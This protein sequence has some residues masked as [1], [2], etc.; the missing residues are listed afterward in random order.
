M[1][2]FCGT[3]NKSA[4]VIFNYVDYNIELPEGK[5]KTTKS[6]SDF[7]KKN[8]KTVT[9]NC[10]GKEEDILCFESWK[11]QVKPDN[12]GYYAYI[13]WKWEKCYK[14]V[15][16]YLEGKLTYINPDYIVRVC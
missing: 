1:L 2:H 3:K 14:S 16:G 8:Y 11:K 13:P 9:V 4:A 10:D 15:E 6:A 5:V 7:R 12:D